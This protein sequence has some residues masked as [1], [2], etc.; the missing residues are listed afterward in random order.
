MKKAILLLL[1]GLSQSV[2]GGRDFYSIL[3]VKRSANNAEI[4]KAYRKLSLQHHP[5]KNPDDADA[6]RKFQDISAGKHIG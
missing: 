6:K 1:L 5:D 2:M 3:G 4:K